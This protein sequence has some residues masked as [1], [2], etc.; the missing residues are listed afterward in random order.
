MAANCDVAVIAGRSRQAAR[1]IGR[2]RVH[3]SAEILI[4]YGAIMQARLL[5]RRQPILFPEPSRRVVL[6]LVVPIV[7]HLLVVFVK[8]RLVLAVLIASP[9]AV[10]CKSSAG[11][12]DENSYYSRAKQSMCIHE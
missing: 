7:R 8:P 11:G 9:P 2:R 10:L 4:Q 5:I 1:Q 3:L 6:M 12:Q